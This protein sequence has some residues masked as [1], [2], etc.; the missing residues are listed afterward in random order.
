MIQ[1]KVTG[2]NSDEDV[3]KITEQLENIGALN[4]IMVTLTSDTAGTI[5]VTGETTD[6]ELH[7]A[8]NRAGDYT[9]AEIQRH[10]ID[11]Y[12]RDR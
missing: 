8:I 3:A 11:P 10:G 12:N 5:I 7:D 9:L 2:I 6:S 4:E 1:L